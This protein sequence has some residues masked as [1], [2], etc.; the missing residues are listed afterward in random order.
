[1]INS[2]NEKVRIFL[3][4]LQTVDN[5]VYDNILEMREIIFKIYPLVGEKMMYGGILFSI[6]TE[7]FCGLF[8]YK[9]HASIEF[10][11]GYLMKDE[12][13]ILEGKGKFRRH[14]KIWDINDIAI[15]DVEGF[16]KQAI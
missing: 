5:G 13:N 14:L 3:T 10:S 6:E 7:M 8:A 1:V 11:N 2:T 16:V 12:K 9:N 15:K 4:D